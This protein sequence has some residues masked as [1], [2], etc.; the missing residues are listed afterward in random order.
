[1]IRRAGRAQL[2]E[3]SVVLRKAPSFGGCRLR[4]EVSSSELV[5]DRAHAS[6]TLGPPDD[7]HDTR[8][9]VEQFPL[10]L[11]GV[12]HAWQLLRRRL[13]IAAVALA[14]RRF[15][16]GVLAALLRQGPSDVVLLVSEMALVVA[17]HVSLVAGFRLYQLSLRDLRFP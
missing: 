9:L 13:A 5:D 2:G 11:L 7:R 3:K 6:D 17:A 15:V 4:V 8:I 10:G 12:E 1:M 16:F 14:S